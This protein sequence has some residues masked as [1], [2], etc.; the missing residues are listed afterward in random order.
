[1][2][3][4]SHPTASLPSG[5]PAGAKYCHNK[6]NTGLALGLAYQRGLVCQEGLIIQAYYCQ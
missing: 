6:E 2:R 1:M 5:G 4:L 3:Q